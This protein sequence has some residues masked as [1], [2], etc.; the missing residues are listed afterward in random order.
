MTNSEREY[1]NT[2]TPERLKSFRKAVSEGQKDGF[3]R[4]RGH[5]ARARI[6]PGGKRILIGINRRKIDAVIGERKGGLK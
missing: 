3:W 5:A 6:C 1:F 2:F 4:G